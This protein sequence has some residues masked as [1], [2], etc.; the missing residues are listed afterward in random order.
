MDQDSAAGRGREDGPQRRRRRR[1]R[2]RQ[3]HDKA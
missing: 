1:R 2:R 3:C